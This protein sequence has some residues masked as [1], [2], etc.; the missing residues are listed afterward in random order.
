VEQNRNYTEKSDI[1]KFPDRYQFRFKERFD[2]LYS[3]RQGQ[4]IPIINIR[5][6]YLRG[7]P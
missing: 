6:G 1:I 2:I 7:R 3:R 5:E 4:I